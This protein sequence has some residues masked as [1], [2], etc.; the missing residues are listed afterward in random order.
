M[1]TR[2]LRLIAYCAVAFISQSF[3]KF[4]SDQ[5]VKNHVGSGMRLRKGIDLPSKKTVSVLNM[6]SD[7]LVEHVQ[8][9]VEKKQS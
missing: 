6:S 7:D 1:K 4:Q 8:M 5:Q 9:A 3:C 2:K